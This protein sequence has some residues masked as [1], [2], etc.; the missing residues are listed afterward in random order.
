MRHD[1]RCSHHELCGSSVKTDKCRLHRRL[2]LSPQKPGIRQ[3]LHHGCQSSHRILCADDK[4]RQNKCRHAR[5]SV[6]GWPCRPSRLPSARQREGAGGGGRGRGRERER[7]GEREG[8]R[9]TV[10]AAVCAPERE[11][12]SPFLSTWLAR[13]RHPTHTHT[14]PLMATA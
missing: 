11:R 14:P 1:L 7:E 8:E 5:T 13:S 6:G 12:E 9:K 2:T 3:S 4:E 10:K